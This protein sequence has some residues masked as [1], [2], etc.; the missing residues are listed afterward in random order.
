MH[1]RRQFLGSIENIGRGGAFVST[2][3][4]EEAVSVGVSVVVVFL[5]PESGSEQ[6]LRGTVL[7]MQ[8]YFH[9]GGLYR[10]LAIKFDEPYGD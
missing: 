2:D 9:E 6:R 5:A 1:S 7:R 3:T 8:R 4:L 10:A